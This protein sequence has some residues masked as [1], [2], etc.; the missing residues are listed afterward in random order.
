MRSVLVQVVQVSCPFP[1]YTRAGGREVAPSAPESA[2]SFGPTVS[3]SN[4]GCAFTFYPSGVMC[5]SGR[6]KRSAIQAWVAELS[7]ELA[8]AT[9]R[10]IYAH[11]GA[12][13]SQA[14]LDG[15]IVRNPARKM[16]LP[17]PMSRAV[18]PLTDDQVEALLDAS[19]EWRGAIALAVGS[20]LRSAEM[21]ALRSTPDSFDFL[22]RVVH[23]REQWRDE[24]QSL[25]GPKSDA[26]VRDVP[27]ADWVLEEVSEH[28]DRFN[29]QPGGY[30]FKKPKTQ[31][32]FRADRL[33]W[34]IRHAAEEAGIERSDG[35]VLHW[36]DLR[37]RYASDL[38]RAGMN[39]KVIQRFMGHESITQTFDVYGS[40]FVDD[41]E[42]A[43]EALNR[44]R[45]TAGLRSLRGLG[46]V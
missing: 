46:T 4:I 16:P 25:I 42:R 36:H 10:A 1:P 21:R 19:G 3:P 7:N 35:N 32:P 9:V 37:H 44:L 8:P 28:C 23:V 27:L 39:P 45:P 26:G 5:Q 13:M 22:G 31:R 12:V 33:R 24:T 38:I 2:L 18:V 34:I 29:V 41:D 20:G 14:E 40:L 15:I 30:L 43:R 11:F 17:K 6:Y